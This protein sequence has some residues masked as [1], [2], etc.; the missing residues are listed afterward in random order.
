MWQALN[1]YELY[2]HRKI[3]LTLVHVRGIFLLD[4]HVRNSDD[5]FAAKICRDSG[6][7]RNHQ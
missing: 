2:T 6:D 3:P 1:R 4:D 7:G 5:A